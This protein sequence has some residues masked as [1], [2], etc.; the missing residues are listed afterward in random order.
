MLNEEA[1]KGI[2]FE[3]SQVWIQKKIKEIVGKTEIMNLDDTEF[4]TCECFIQDFLENVEEK[5]KGDFYFERVG[6]ASS[7]LRF[8]AFINP[9]IEPNEIEEEL[10]NLENFLNE[11][12]IEYIK[13]GGYNVVNNFISEI[14]SER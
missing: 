10:E 13:Q 1:I 3:I 6:L 8:L 7:Q 4:N 11:E 5:C 12:K 9:V 14:Y 2:G